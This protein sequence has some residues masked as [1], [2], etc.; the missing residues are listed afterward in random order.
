MGWSCK[1]CEAKPDADGIV[2]HGRGCYQ[3]SA[4]GGGEEYV[5]PEPIV[6]V[7]IPA[8]GD[9][10]EV[11]RSGRY[12]AWRVT[13]ITPPS[14]NG[15]GGLIHG[16]RLI[17][18]ETNMCIPVVT[19]PPGGWR[20]VEDANAKGKVRG[21]MGGDIGGGAGIDDGD[22]DGGKESTPSPQADPARSALLAIRSHLDAVAGSADVSIDIG[23][24][25]DLVA[26]GLGEER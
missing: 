4:D 13:G 22:R 26:E 9:L 8:I 17:T 2:E 24:L 19:D 7:D 12:Q 3:V 5:T 23:H 21:W 14:P 16:T 18:G 11:G 10:I 20:R 15:L 6:S 25:R 1:V